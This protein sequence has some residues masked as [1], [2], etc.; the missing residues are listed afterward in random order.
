MYLRCI[1]FEM[2]SNLDNSSAVG[3]PEVNTLLLGRHDSLTDFI[4]R[5]RSSR[6]INT[7]TNDSFATLSLN[8]NNRQ[9]L[10]PQYQSTVSSAIETI[11]MHSI[12]PINPRTHTDLNIDQYRS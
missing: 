11:M 8:I 9:L 4:Y 10:I 12:N 1:I 5:R 3:L 6:L 7:S 2:S